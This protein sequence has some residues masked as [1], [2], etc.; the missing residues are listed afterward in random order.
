MGIE[1]LLATYTKS[2]KTFPLNAHNLVNVLD[3]L[4]HVPVTGIMFV[5]TAGITGMFMGQSISTL[6]SVL[7]HD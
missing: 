4:S 1:Q 3:H 2:V 7:R 6:T 5:G